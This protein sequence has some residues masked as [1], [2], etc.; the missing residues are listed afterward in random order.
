[1]DIVS[2]VCEYRDTRC[3]GRKDEERGKGNQLVYLYTA[4]MA[5]MSQNRGS[6]NGVGG[7]GEELEPRRQGNAQIMKKKREWL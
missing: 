7:S 4:Q 1:M 2:S 3:E 6:F 5:C